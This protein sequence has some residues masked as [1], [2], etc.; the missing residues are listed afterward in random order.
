[1]VWASQ[2]RWKA[3]LE[4]L[5]DIEGCGTLPCLCIVLKRIVCSK[6]LN[7]KNVSVTCPLNATV[8]IKIK[9]LIILRINAYHSLI[10]FT[11]FFSLSYFIQFENLF[12]QKMEQNSNNHELNQKSKPTPENNLSN[13]IHYVCGLY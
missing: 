8:Q 5:N 6:L 3:R 13:E 4:A 10:L 2:R 9:Q 11:T 12:N 1:M 7:E